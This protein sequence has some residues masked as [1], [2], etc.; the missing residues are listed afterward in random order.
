MPSFTKHSG[1][2]LKSQCHSV[3]SR[4]GS[5]LAFERKFLRLHFWC[6]PEELML[7]GKI[8]SIGTMNVKFFKFS[9][10]TSCS[11]L[12]RVIQAGSTSLALLP[13]VT[14]GSTTPE[15]APSGRWKF[16]ESLGQDAEWTRNSAL[17]LK[18]YC[19]IMPQNRNKANS[20]LLLFA[21]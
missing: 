9:D 21:I 20:H 5:L 1:V 8:T 15:L 10:F 13:P 16:I 11:W 19:T 18:V 3:M 2:R 7:R 17:R 6:I 12:L 4:L 14:S